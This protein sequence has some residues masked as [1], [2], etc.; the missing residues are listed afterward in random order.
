M[1]G[2]ERA[3]LSSWAQSP[4]VSPSPVWRLRACGDPYRD[5]SGKLWAVEKGVQGGDTTY[6]DRPLKAGPD[7]ELYRGERWGDDFSY[8]LPVP[9]GSYRVRLKFIET[10]VKE[11][12]GRVFDVF[13]NGKKVLDRF[14][15]LAEA[16]GFEKAVDKVF[17]GVQPDPN[18]VLTVRFAAKTQKA[19]VCALEVVRRP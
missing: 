16:G 12:G 3:A 14:D 10:Y 13:L 15:I 7:A 11:K 4:T 6:A 17:S 8:V 1:H 18:G 19:K 9:P 2:G 5:K